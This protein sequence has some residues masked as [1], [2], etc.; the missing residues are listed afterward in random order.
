MPTGALAR[1][2]LSCFRSIG[3]SA[4]APA[5]FLLRCCAAAWCDQI[6]TL[7][8]NQLFLIRDTVTPIAIRTAS[9]SYSLNGCQITEK[10]ELL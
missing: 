6:P 4:S 2:G 7:A 10:P 9:G 1:R 8:E 5:L 3:A